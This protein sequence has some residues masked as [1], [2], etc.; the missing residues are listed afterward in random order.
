MTLEDMISSLE[1]V[2]ACLK[3][4]A[5]EFEYRSAA[6]DV[7][8]TRDILKEVIDALKRAEEPR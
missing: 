4:V 5:G 1:H 7:E 6:D 2:D 3:W 8:T